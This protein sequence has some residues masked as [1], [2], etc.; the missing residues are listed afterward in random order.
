MTAKQSDKYALEELI[1]PLRQQVL[2][3]NKHYEES[4]T[5]AKDIM[6]QINDLAS[7][8]KTGGHN[9]NTIR[10]SVEQSMDNFGKSKKQITDKVNEASYLVD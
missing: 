6:S 5:T 8:V 1:N 3:M 7:A 2:D 4:R 9:A 10:Q